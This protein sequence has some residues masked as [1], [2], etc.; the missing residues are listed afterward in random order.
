[1]TNEDIQNFIV[2]TGFDV[3]L[4]PIE[5]GPAMEVSTFSQRIG[6]DQQDLQMQLPW[7]MNALGQ[8]TVTMVP[9][10]G[11]YD[12]VDIK[13]PMDT[14]NATPESPKD[15]N[16]HSTWICGAIGAIN[17]EI[18]YRGYAAETGLIPIKV[19][20][21][22]G[23]GSGADIEKAMR[24]ALEWWTR[25]PD[26]PAKLGGTGKLL[27]CFYSMS[28]GGGGYSQREFQ[29]FQDMIKVGIIP[30]ASSGNESRRSPSYPAAYD[31]VRKHGAYG[32]GRLKA[33]F[34]NYGPWTDAVGPGVNVPSTVNSRDYANYSGTSM[35]NPIIVAT[36]ASFVS[37]H[38]N[39]T[40][41]HDAYGLSEAIAEHM[42]NLPGDWDGKGV[43]LPAKAI[44]RNEH[45]IF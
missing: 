9:D 14:Y 18:G 35:S 25:H 40:W 31:G 34:T 2:E 5:R 29:L 33:S 41:L 12:H 24:W 13:A 22:S 11:V 3:G 28:Y 43:F 27:T 4:P 39:D 36:L 19:L 23:S 20:R 8:R 21:D 16:N 32:K 37:A 26:R 6:W 30:C 1:M 15:R 45:F 44:T 42:E 7:D 17:N 38:P 10:T